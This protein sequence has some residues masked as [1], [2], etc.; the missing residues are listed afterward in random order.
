M[1][2]H[3]A[4]V[5]LS[6]L[7]LGLVAVALP[8]EAAAQEG[9]G[10]A[11]ADSAAHPQMPDSVA[12]MQQMQGMSGMMGMMYRQMTEVMMEVTL[13]VLTRPESAEKL[14]TFTRNYYEALLR[15]GF[16][17]EQAIRIVAA[18]GVPSSPMAPAR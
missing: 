18:A 9:A 13:E 12:L 2:S 5:G 8:F 14:A 15:K 16:T 7:A 11:R 10:E 17:E 6:I 1:L 3:Y 4:R